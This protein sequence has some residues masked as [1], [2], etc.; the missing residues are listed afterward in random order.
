MKFVVHF[1]A[2]MVVGVLVA[3]VC[4]GEDSGFQPLKDALQKAEAARPGS[5]AKDKV[6]YKPEYLTP[7]LIALEDCFSKPA[8][9][10]LKARLQFEPHYSEPH[11]YTKIIRKENQNAKYK[12]IGGSYQYVEVE[13]KDKT[14]HIESYTIQG[15]DVE[16]LRGA[17]AVCLALELAL[18]DTALDTKEARRQCPALKEAHSLMQQL[19]RYARQYMEVEGVAASRY[20]TRLA[21]VESLRD[22]VAAIQKDW[23]AEMKKF[24]KAGK[25]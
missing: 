11:E 4:A 19:P 25:D 13:Q 17:E 15:G 1:M 6:L 5:L 23:Q 21:A 16:A 2:V 14:K 18:K 8:S 9:R 24:R 22:E 3:S 20:K 7:I 12:P 10:I